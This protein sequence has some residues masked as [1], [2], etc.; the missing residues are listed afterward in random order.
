MEDTSSPVPTM[1][2]LS[3]PLSSLSQSHD[4]KQSQDVKEEQLLGIGHLQ[5]FLLRSNINNTYSK[6]PL[7][8]IHNDGI[9]IFLN[10]MI[11][12]K[13][14]GPAYVS[15]DAEP[16]VKYLL[17]SSFFVPPAALDIEKDFIKIQCT[18]KTLPISSLSTDD[19]TNNTANVDGNFITIE[20]PGDT[21]NSDNKIVKVPIDIIMVDKYT[22]GL[23]NGLPITIIRHNDGKN[24]S[25]VVHEQ[26]GDLDGESPEWDKIFKSVEARMKL[27]TMKTVEQVKLELSKA[28]EL[29]KSKLN[30]QHPNNNG[31]KGEPQ[32]EI[33][34]TKRGSRKQKVTTLN[35]DQV[36]KMME[37]VANVVKKG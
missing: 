11:G 17:F 31:S 12:G 33:T 15:F 4:D 16:D 18:G 29:N 1:A 13:L 23:F 27:L 20:E 7:A 28:R 22:A 26:V 36:T 32:I 8:G 9:T 6:W 24:V 2:V 10:C 3:P 14:K 25:I 37:S 30:K 5:N 35:V 34:Q 21:K 19:H